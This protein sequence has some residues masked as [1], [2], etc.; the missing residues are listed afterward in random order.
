MELLWLRSKSLDHP[1]RQIRPH[2]LDQLDLR[3][4]NWLVFKVAKNKGNKCCEREED[5]NQQQP[6]NRKYR[7]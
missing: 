1:N 7:L 2:L 5:R 6:V 3:S 4:M